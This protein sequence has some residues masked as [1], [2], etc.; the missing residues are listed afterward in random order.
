MAKITTKNAYEQSKNKFGQEVSINFDNLDSLFATGPEIFSALD[1]AKQNFESLY[2]KLIT[3]FEEMRGEII[4]SKDLNDPKLIEKELRK[5]RMDEGSILGDLQQVLEGEFTGLNDNLFV[6][7]KNNT[8][9]TPELNKLLTDYVNSYTTYYNAFC[10]ATE[11]GEKIG[12]TLRNEKQLHQMGFLTEK[13]LTEVFM[14]EKTM[15]AFRQDRNIFF[16]FLEAAKDSTGRYL[17]E[18]GQAKIIRTSLSTRYGLTENNIIDSISNLYQQQNNIGFIKTRT[19]LAGSNTYNL[20]MDLFGDEQLLAGRWSEAMMSGFIKGNINNIDTT[21]EEF[22]DNLMW[23]WGGDQNFTYN[24]QRYQISQKNLDLL[25][26]TNSNYGFRLGTLNS[27]ESIRNLIYDSSSNSTDNYWN[28][29]YVNGNR[30]MNAMT[31]YY[32]TGDTMDIPSQPFDSFYY[33]II[34]E[35]SNYGEV[36]DMGGDWF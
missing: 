20:A 6:R 26:Y 11:F 32:Q 25:N 21:S 12:T 36:I 8:Q 9:M 22:R 31:Y 27:L 2:M 15:A 4:N 16:F 30:F 17:I 29:S 23:F 14:D 24:G 19:V 10:S 28:G 5:I 34:K 13:G 33:D 18:N 3:L 7:L 1:E 35:F